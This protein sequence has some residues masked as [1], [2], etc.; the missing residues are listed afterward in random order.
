M[1]L[2]EEQASL[3]KGLLARGDKQHDIA[4]FFGENAGRIADIATGK[5]FPEVQAAPRKDL[6]TVSAL[7]SGFAVHAAREALRRAR[8]GIDAA[9]TYLD[10]YE[11]DRD[12]PSKD[13]P[14]NGKA[15][16]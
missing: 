6:P 4:S 3:V 10:I 1:A 16:R 2:N 5:K 9:F 14:K 8:T 13:Q 7:M 15:K 12:R 11:A